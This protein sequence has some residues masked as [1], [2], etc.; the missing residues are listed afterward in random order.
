MGGYRCVV[1]NTNMIWWMVVGWLPAVL[2]WSFGDD[3]F[4]TAGGVV[5]IGFM[6]WVLWKRSNPT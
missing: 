4:T 2:L 3:L 5:W 1:S 6:Y